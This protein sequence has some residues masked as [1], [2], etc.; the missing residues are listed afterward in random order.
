MVA[1]RAFMATGAPGAGW[2][3][4]RIELGAS[5]MPYGAWTGGAAP[6]GP[7][8]G[9][10]G[11]LGGGVASSPQDARANGD[12]T[13]SRLT[14]RLMERRRFMARPA[15]AGG[16]RRGRAAESCRAASGGRCHPCTR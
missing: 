15:G 6:A 10:V 14:K 12:T 2:S 5:F 1:A 7:V 16:G 3:Y 9:R 8:T 4:G 13:A 11:A